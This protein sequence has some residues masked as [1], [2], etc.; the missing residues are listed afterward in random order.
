[1]YRTSYGVSLPPVI[2]YRVK[3]HASRDRMLENAADTCFK[4]VQNLTGWPEMIDIVCA[5]DE[6]RGSSSIKSCFSKSI[7]E[8][9]MFDARDVDK[10][11]R[12]CRN[13]SPP[14]DSTVIVE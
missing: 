2:L 10:I 1:M 5:G 4:V 6:N 9:L 11:T 12:E 14:E 3:D 7:S 13:K 8:Y